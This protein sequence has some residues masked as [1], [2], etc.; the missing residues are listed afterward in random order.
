[1]LLACSLQ[2][3]APSSKLTVQP[4]GQL[5]IKRGQSAV[6]TVNVSTLPGFHVNS[7]KP[8]EEFLIP[9]Q[10]T[11]SSG[12]LHAGKV[13]YPS[14]EDIQV[15]GETLSVFTGDFVLKT[16]F[17]APSDA[18]AGSS[19]IVGKLHYQACNNRMCFRPATVEVHLPVVVQ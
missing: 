17:T 8:R 6:S 13:V 2:A 16:D 5:T 15:N 11:W 12:V 9:L 19:E 3:Q 1:M 10:L 18:P 4:L 7:D 14:A